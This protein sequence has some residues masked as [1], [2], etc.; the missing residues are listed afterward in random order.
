MRRSRTAVKRVAGWLAV[1]WTRAANFEMLLAHQARGD[2]AESQ[3]EAAA[4]LPPPRSAASWA[5]MGAVGVAAGALFAVTGASANAIRMAAQSWQ[6]LLP[7]S[8]EEQFEEETDCTKP[9][10]ADKGFLKSQMI[11]G[12]EERNVLLLILPGA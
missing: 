4:P 10:S 7:C 5:K 12:V 2:N 8:H 9:H 6:S 1:P 11:N 3:E